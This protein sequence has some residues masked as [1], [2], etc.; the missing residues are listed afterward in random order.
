[1]TLTASAAAAGAALP[2]SGVRG[3]DPSE[4]SALQALAALR[5]GQLSATELLQACR[6]RIAAYEPVVKAFL[7]R[8][9]AVAD[10]AAAR[11]DARYHAGGALPLDGVPVGLKDLYY[12]SGIPTTAASRAL[13]GFVPD[14]DATVWSTLQSAGGVLLGKLNLHEFA[15]NA[16][17]TPTTNPWD[18]TLGPAGSSGG[19]GAAL[20]ARYLPVATGTDTGGS[21]RAPASACGVV[22]MK[23]TYGRV[24][25]HGIVSCCWSLDHAGMMARTVADSAYLLHL[26]QGADPLDPTSLP[27]S[28]TAG[29]G[30]YPLLPR[31]SLQGRRI[32]IPTSFFW[33]GLDAGVEATAR[34]AVDELGRLGAT[35]VDVDLPPSFSPAVSGDYGDI[36]AGLLNSVAGIFPTIGGSELAAYHRH[37]IE[38]AGPQA[39]SPATLAVI[40]SGLTIRARDYLRAQQ[41]RTVLRREMQQVLTD[42]RLDA[43]AHP[44]LP[45][46]PPRQVPVDSPSQA[47]DLSRTQPWDLCGFPSLTLPVGLDRGGVPVGLLLSGPPLTEAAL[48]EIGLA[49]EA[50]LA[51][52]STHRPALLS[53]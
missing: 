2:A 30:D 20:A 22:G 36:T 12:T 6:A 48:F 27:D 49:L 47:A 40:E 19:S 53:T 13:A 33:N 39:Y 23:P 34:A 15:V 44:T 31:T 41:M 18:T 35:V 10:A 52:A 16:Q 42:A 11:S 8:T 7:T 5:A 43:M 25:R 14:H 50:A 28:V 32:G 24:S 17:T 29:A 51:F 3:S 4:L 46:A 1:M 45:A 21:I 38:Q 37:L 26:V 9:D